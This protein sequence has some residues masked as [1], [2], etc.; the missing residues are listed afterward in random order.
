MPDVP[1]DLIDQQFGNLTA[2]SRVRSGKEGIVWRCRCV[3]GVE[4]EVPTSKLV[5]GNTRFCGCM[6]RRN[7]ASAR[8]ALKV[9][10]G[11]PAG[12]PPIDISVA[13]L[14]YAG[15]VW[16]MAADV[17]GTAGVLAAMWW[18]YS[19]ETSSPAARDRVGVGNA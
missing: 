8:K 17:S 7:T 2:L 10:I 14:R 3:C 11:S 13:W 16:A 19:P 9:P 6:K 4:T 1:R 18:M 5:S 12:R 15:L